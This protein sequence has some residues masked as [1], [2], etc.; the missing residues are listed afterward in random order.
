VWATQGPLK[1]VNLLR[2]LFLIAKPVPDDK[3]HVLT[4]FTM[5]YEAAVEML[6]IFLKLRSAEK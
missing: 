3:V 2:R 1:N 5:K 6:N 4:I